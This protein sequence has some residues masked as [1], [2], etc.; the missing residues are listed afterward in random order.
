MYRID[1]TTPQSYSNGDDARIFAECFTTWARPLCD[2]ME[3]FSLLSCACV[4]RLRSMPLMRQPHA[5]HPFSA[6]AYPTLPLPHMGSAPFGL[7]A[8]PW[9]ALAIR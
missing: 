4:A 3:G 7:Q 6:T 1:P 8:A 2:G 9:V 5:F